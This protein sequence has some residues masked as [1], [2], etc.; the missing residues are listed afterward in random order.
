MAAG[1]APNDFQSLQRTDVYCAE[2]PPGSAAFI[3]VVRS[4]NKDWD[5]RDRAGRYWAI[6]AAPAHRV[7]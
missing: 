4:K 5:R 3:R 6:E 1:I 2:G 7:H